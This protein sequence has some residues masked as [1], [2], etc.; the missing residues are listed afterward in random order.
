MNYKI[1]K[2]ISL[3]DY[4][5][6]YHLG[7]STIYKLLLNNKILI[8]GKIIKSNTI[9][10][11]NDILTIIADKNDLMPFKYEFKVLYEDDY[12]LII[13]KPYGH[14]IHGSFDAVD[15]MVS[16]YYQKNNLDIKVRHVHRLDK[17]TTGILVYAKD[18]L[19]E[20][21]FNYHLANHDFIREYIALV[22]GNLKKDLVIEKPI[23]KDRH[24]N[25]KY[26]ISKTGKYAKTY[27]HVLKHDVD[28]SLLLI[29][30]ETGRTHQIRVHLESVNH[31]L[32]NDPIYNYGTGKMFLRSF[33]FKFKHPYTNL[34]IYIEA[35]NEK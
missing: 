22:K 35:P 6:S 11:K 13:D 12:I 29:R 14:I 9:L 8:N 1:F 27:V 3:N 2:K 19:T 33:S 24:N 31:P 34:E 20:A 21:Y 23:G 7:K 4:L 25:N 32:I 10:N 15:N 30:L 5:L 28:K 26:V 16:Y 17:E 18:I